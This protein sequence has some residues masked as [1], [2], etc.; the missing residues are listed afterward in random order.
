MLAFLPIHNRAEMTIQFI[1]RLQDIL[2]SQIKL[3]V[4]LLDAG[5]TDNVFEK[6]QQLDADIKHIQLDTSYF[7]GKSLNKIL[8]II[9]TESVPNDCLVGIFNNDTLQFERSLRRGIELLDRHDVMAPL[10]L[11][12]DQRFKATLESQEPVP[13]K[14]LI[15]RFSAYIDYGMN[16]DTLQGRFVARSPVQTPNLSHTLGT[17]TRAG[18]LRCLPDSLVP[19]DIPHYLSDYYLTYSL[20]QRN[21]QL[22]IDPAYFVVRFNNV[23]HAVLDT[24]RAAA[25][26]ESHNPRSRI[27]QPAILRFR[28]DFSKET[29]KQIKILIKKVSY[30]THM[31]LNR[32]S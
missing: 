16:F 7:W 5:S 8:E 4:F 14:E 32:T 6:V 17:L 12:I 30:Q 28:E 20:T 26:R 11:E 9:K 22:A 24:D 18:V 19:P 31:L 21:F 25:R 2:D 15:S 1:S 27:Y 29:G 10:S 3:T 23:G 13:F